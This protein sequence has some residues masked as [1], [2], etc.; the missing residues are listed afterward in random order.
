LIG[1]TGYLTANFVV[2][3]LVYEGGI[4]N[5]F[6]NTVQ[7]YS[8]LAGCVAG[9]SLSSLGTILTSLLTNNI[10]SEEDVAKEWEKTIS[11]DNPLNPWQ[12]LYKEEFKQFPPG[13][14]PTAAI[15][16]K[17]FRSA[18]FV[19]IFGGLGFVSLFLV[20]IPAV[21]MSFDVL[22]RDQFSS[23]VTFCYVICFIGAVFVV[24]A[25]PAEEIYQIIRT[26]KSSGEKQKMEKMSPEIEQSRL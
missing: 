25:P 26:W 2:S 5:F 18:R 10:K 13:T 11:I 14:K 4:S 6:T 23:Y 17:I 24:V 20:V 19:A 1:L 3:E 15:M 21:V 22:T 16:A 7:D 12:R 9:I 8:L